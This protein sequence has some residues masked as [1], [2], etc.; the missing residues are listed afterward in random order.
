MKPLVKLLLAILVGIAAARSNVHAGQGDE[1]G[2]DAQIRQPNVAIYRFNALE[3]ERG[4]AT[5]RFAFASTIN[6]YTLTGRNGSVIAKDVFYVKTFGG[7][8]PTVEIH[9][10]GDQ[11]IVF[12]ETLKDSGV[13][14]ASENPMDAV[15]HIYDLATGKIILTSEKYRYDHDVP[16]RYDP[17]VIVRLAAKA[18]KPE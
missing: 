7:M 5:R 1:G 15:T 18:V 4:V 17:M 12:P 16:L 10:L 8:A 9:L 13:P 2:A 6:G 3:S 14:G 11:H